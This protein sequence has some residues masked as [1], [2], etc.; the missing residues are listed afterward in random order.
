MLILYIKGSE[1][2]DL[3]YSPLFPSSPVAPFKIIPASFV[4]PET[5]TGI[6]HCAPAHGAEDYTVLHSLHLFDTHPLLCHVDSEGR[7]SKD[8]CDVIGMERGQRLVGLPV[9]TQ[10][11]SVV[12]EQLKEMGVLLNETSIKHRYPYDWKTDKPVIVT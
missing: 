5:G 3:H 11:T 2:V 4:S 10:G 7:Y 9:L 12:I 6:V 8:V 1:L